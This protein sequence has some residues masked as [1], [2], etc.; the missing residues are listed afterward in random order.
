M[1]MFFKRSLARRIAA[2]VHGTCGRDSLY[3]SRM[4]ARECRTTE[5]DLKSAVRDMIINFI[6]PGKEEGGRG[7]K[8]R[9]PIDFAVLLRLTQAA[10]A[11]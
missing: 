8:G 2:R 6:V 1:P 7:G 9:L 5:I 3:K 11:S 4:C 10:P